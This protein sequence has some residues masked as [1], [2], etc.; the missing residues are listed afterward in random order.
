MAAKQGHDRHTSGRA[1]WSRE[2][3]ELLFWETDRAA[4]AGQPVKQAFEAVAQKTGRQPNSIR[5]Y[6][7]MKLREEPGRA[8]AAFVPFGEKELRMLAEAMLIGRAEGKS[9]RSIALQLG[10]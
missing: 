2:E 4:A 5:N 9:V 6:Y 7:Y 1:G 3:T 8:K 10:N